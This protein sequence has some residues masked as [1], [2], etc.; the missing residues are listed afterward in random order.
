MCVDSVKKKEPEK[1]KKKELF[2]SF[3]YL[4]VYKNAFIDI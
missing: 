2:P 1:R 3:K 4:Y